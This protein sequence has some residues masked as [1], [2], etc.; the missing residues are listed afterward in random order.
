MIKEFYDEFETLWSY[1]RGPFTAYL[2]RPAAGTYV[3][4][5]H[6][7]GTPREADQTMAIPPCKLEWAEKAAQYFCDGGIL[8]LNV[9]ALILGY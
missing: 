2:R 1:E 9:D 3:L 7:K 5:G 8:P 4:H 6:V